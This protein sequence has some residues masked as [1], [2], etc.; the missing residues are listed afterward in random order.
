[1][2]VIIYYSQLA[3]ANFKF[4]LLPWLSKCSPSMPQR[5]L[6]K[7]SRILSKLTTLQICP[8]A[9]RVCIVSQPLAGSCRH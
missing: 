5:S 3:L 1:M 8:Y 9:H 6:F 7:F 4:S 2:S